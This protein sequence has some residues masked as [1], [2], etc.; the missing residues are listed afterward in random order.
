M[1]CTETKSDVQTQTDKMCCPEEMCLFLDGNSDWISST[2]HWPQPFHLLFLPPGH[3]GHIS[4]RL[5][6]RW[7]GGVHKQPLSGQMDPLQLVE[8]LVVELGRVGWTPLAAILV[9]QVD[10]IGASFGF[11]HVDVLCG[12]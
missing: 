9:A 8:V 12:F 5:G 7:E 10:D 2:H 11:R 4:Q 3:A 6:V 1:S